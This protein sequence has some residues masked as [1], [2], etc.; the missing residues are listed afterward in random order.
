[1][2]GYSP[3]HDCLQW[4]T[5]SSWGHDVVSRTPDSHES[6]RRCVAARSLGSARRAARPRW[7]GRTGPHR[8]YRYV[9]DD[10][11][12][13]AV[14]VKKIETAP[15][16]IVGM[17]EGL[18]TS[19]NHACPGGVK[20]VNFNTYM[21]QRSSFGKNFSNFG[22]I[23]SSIEGHIVIVRPDMDRISTILCRAAPTDVPIEQQFHQI[24]RALGVGNGDTGYLASV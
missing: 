17:A 24:R 1:M 10:L 13:D 18:E 12:L 16:L 6:H 2:P 7:R 22:G 9:A 20:V 11:I 8:G 4:Q 23:A 3:L 14:W 15:W 19:S 21:I 5:A